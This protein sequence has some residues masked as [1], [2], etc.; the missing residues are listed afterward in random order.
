MIAI[1]STPAGFPGVASRGA[2]DLMRPS[3]F[4][5]AHEVMFVSR[6]TVGS[7]DVSTPAPSRM[8]WILFVGFANSPSFTMRPAQYAAKSG[9]T[10]PRC[11]A[12]CSRM[13]PSTAFATS[14]GVASAG[15]FSREVSCTGSSVCRGAGP[16]PAERIPRAHATSSRRSTS[17]RTI[18]RRSTAVLASAA[19]NSNGVSTIFQ[20]ASPTVVFSDFQRGTG[21][22]LPVPMTAT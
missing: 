20:R 9:G 4:L 17:T 12:C 21:L 18:Q 7:R 6:E 11:A 1:S 19:A 22:K 2:R 5:P 13:Y 8:S 16:R 15:F 10:R 14:P 3:R